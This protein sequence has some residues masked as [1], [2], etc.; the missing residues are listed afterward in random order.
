MSDEGESILNNQYPEDDLD[1]AVL[2]GKQLKTL[3]VSEPLQEYAETND[4]DIHGYVFEAK[5]E[6]LREPRVVRVGVIQ[7]SIVADTSQPVVEQRDAIHQVIGKIIHAA[8]DLKV[9]V[10]CLQE[11]WTMPFAFCT[12]ERLPWLEFAESAEFGPSTRFLQKFAKE[13]NMVIISPILE[14]EENTDLIWNTAVV[15][16]N[17]G[18]VKGKHRKN[19]IPR[20]GDFNESTYY[21]EGNTGHPVFKTEFGNIAVNICY[22]RHHPLNWLMFGLN[23]AEIVFNPSAT[24]GALSEPLWSLEARTAAIAN[25]YY[26]CAINRVG[27]ETFPN[28]FTSGDGQPAHNNFGHFYGSS[29]I[30]GPDGSRTPSLSRTRN[31]LLVAD[32]DLNM[33][34]QVRD[35]WGFRM[36]MRLEDYAKE[37]TRAASPDFKPQLIN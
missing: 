28:E 37:L 22:G 27:T 31:G 14:R 29:Y 33:C 5:E 23:G 12:R 20:V 16:D 19:H 4:F 7:N 1:K 32:L 25:H 6:Q 21:M 18:Q 10:L 8:A 9:N 13:F 3:K 15:I 11:A 26:T 34:R 17:Y 2:F 24:V 36:T 35:S 30:T